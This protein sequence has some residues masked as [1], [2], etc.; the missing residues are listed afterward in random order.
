M[1]DVP[2]PTIN[3]PIYGWR[4][5]CQLHI[6]QSLALAAVL[7]RTVHFALSSG[8]DEYRVPLAAG[9]RACRSAGPSNLDVDQASRSFE[10]QIGFIEWGLGRGIMAMVLVLLASRPPLDC[11]VWRINLLTSPLSISCR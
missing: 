8:W 6:H 7:H 9:S 11:S 2:Y 4:V 1:V 3:A 5:R 10:Y